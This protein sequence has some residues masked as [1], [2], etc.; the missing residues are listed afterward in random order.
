VGYEQKQQAIEARYLAA[1][2]AGPTDRQRRSAQ[3][4]EC[5]TL[6]LEDQFLKEVDLLMRHEELWRQLVPADCLTLEGTA[7]AF[8]FSSGAGCAVECVLVDRYTKSPFNL[9]LSLISD[10][11]AARLEA[12]PFCLHP[13]WALEVV[14]D[15]FAEPLKL[16]SPIAQEKLRLAARLLRTCISTL[17]SLHASIRRRILSRGIQC[18]AIDFMKLSADVV[19]DRSRTQARPVRGTP[20]APP[21]GP[22]VAGGDVEPDGNVV[23]KDESVT[24]PGGAW[25]QFLHEQLEGG[26]GTAGFSCCRGF[27]RSTRPFLQRRCRGYVGS[28][29]QPQS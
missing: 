25:R 6:R 24:R 8:S 11:D 2:L 7:A 19:C 12:S 9:F 17:E 23:V 20:P 14:M 21:S 18:K 15:A 10:E 27:R 28:G 16:C 5:A 3:V 4:L 26:A 13:A 29:R 22:C 1:R